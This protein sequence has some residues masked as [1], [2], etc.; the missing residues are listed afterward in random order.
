M[1]FASLVILVDTEFCGVKSNGRSAGRRRWLGCM[2][3]PEPD[4]HVYQHIRAADDGGRNVDEETEVGANDI[5]NDEEHGPSTVRSSI[6]E[7]A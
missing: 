4:T 5:G 1:L 2:R 7:D 6:N 3:P